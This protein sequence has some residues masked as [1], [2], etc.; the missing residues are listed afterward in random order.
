MLRRRVLAGI[1]ALLMGV[2]LVFTLSA[3]AH[4]ISLANAQ[5]MARDYARSVRKGSKGK[6]LHYSTDCY[7]LFQDHNHYVRCQ[8][9]YTDDEKTGGTNSAV[10]R[11]TIDV[12]FQ[13]HNA[14]ERSNYW[15]KH[16]SGQCGSR[17]F[18]GT[19]WRLRAE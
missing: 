12:F 17:S 10:C 5:E 18:R 8:I 2:S 7:K 11:E 13:P 19:M 16:H 6:Y 1:A 14:G 3:S 4:N 15:I 9:D